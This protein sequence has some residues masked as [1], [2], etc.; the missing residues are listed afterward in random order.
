[1]CNSGAVTAVISAGTGPTGH[2]RLVCAGTVSLTSRFPSALP[3]PFFC[4]DYR[5]PIVLP[6]KGVLALGVSG[7]RSLER[8]PDGDQTHWPG[9]L[10]GQLVRLSMPTASP[11]RPA[12]V[13]QPWGR[14]S[15]A[16]GAAR[17]PGLHRPAPPVP[18]GLK[19][20]GG[21]VAAAS[22]PSSLS[23]LPLPAPPRLS[24]GPRSAGTRCRWVPARRRESG[25]PGRNCGRC[26]GASHRRGCSAPQ[27]P[28]PAAVSCPAA[29]QGRS[30]TLRR[31]R[32]RGMRGLG[33]AAGGGCQQRSGER[34]RAG[35]GWA[36]GT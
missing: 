10:P 31:G 35:L 12:F 13:P 36:D 27:R 19:G 4:P 8:C 22:L 17:G 34:C 30:F 15:S 3:F 25:R 9:E 29:V 1:M 28:S 6:S 5:V 14:L 2:P 16:R 20:E 24:L 18:A 21:R 23:S 33:V 26:F 32:V 7:Q 11:S